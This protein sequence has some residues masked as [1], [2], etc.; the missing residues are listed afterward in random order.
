MKLF[1]NIGA[2]D[3]LRITPTMGRRLIESTSERKPALG[4]RG[5]AST[6]FAG[7]GFNPFQSVYR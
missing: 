1:E 7:T 6:D 2:G 4:L 5:V 3:E